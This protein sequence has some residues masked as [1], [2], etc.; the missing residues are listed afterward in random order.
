MK[1]EVRGTFISSAGLTVKTSSWVAATENLL[2]TELE[3]EGPDAEV[4]ARLFPAATAIVN[5]DKPIQIGREQNGKGRWFFNGLVDEVHLYDRALNEDEISKL[6]HFED[7]AQGLVRRWDFDAAEGSTPQDTKAKMITG[8]RCLGTQSVEQPDERPMDILGCQ[9]DG[10][11]EDYHP[12]A[13]GI[14]GR[15]AKFMHDYAYL[16]AGPVPPM[17][18]VTVAAWIYI[19]SAGDANFILS[20]G[21][22]NEAY[23]LSLD[24]GRLRFNVGDRFVR[25]QDALPTNRWV[26]VA[27]TF[28]GKILQAYVDGAEV[29]PGARFVTGGAAET[30]SGSA[31][32]PMGR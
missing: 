23:G 20:K 11:H 6:M 1:A 30:R 26:H 12:Y 24:N 18:Q 5:N 4:H 15:A 27:G 8:P 16:D 9:P 29:L 19:F 3:S 13:Q 10:Q 7:P 28:D 31:E 21:D 2:V 32:M 22:W 14:R 17:Q 25:S